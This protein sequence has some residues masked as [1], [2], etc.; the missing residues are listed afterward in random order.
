MAMA[1][2]KRQARANEVT[3]PTLS[4]KTG[5]QRWGARTRLELRMNMYSD[6]NSTHFVMNLVLV[7]TLLGVL[8]S[9]IT[10]REAAVLFGA[11]GGLLVAFLLAAVRGE[12]F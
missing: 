10:H 11:V 5:R 7:G 2:P 8:A 1:S 6:N 9:V 4:P 12:Q 3:D